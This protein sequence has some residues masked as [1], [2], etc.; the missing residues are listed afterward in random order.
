MPT[1]FSTPPSKPTPPANQR[2][3]FSDDANSPMRELVTTNF[4]TPSKPTLNFSEP[5]FSK[6]SK[7]RS[8]FDDNSQIHY[9]DWFHIL[10]NISTLSLNDTTESKENSESKENLKKKKKALLK[11]AL[12]NFQLQATYLPEDLKRLDR[13]TSPLVLE[14]YARGIKTGLWEIAREIQQ[15]KLQAKLNDNQKKIIKNFNIFLTNRPFDYKASNNTEIIIKPKEFN[16]IDSS[17]NL[18]DSNTES[19]YIKSLGLQLCRASSTENKGKE[20]GSINQLMGA[21]G[22]R[23]SPNGSAEIISSEMIEKKKPSDALKLIINQIKSPNNKPFVNH[24]QQI[25]SKPN[26]KVALQNSSL[27]NGSDFDEMSNTRYKLSDPAT[28][29]PKGYLNELL[30]VHTDFNN[31]LTSNNNLP[32]FI[33]QNIEIL[34]HLIGNPS[35][36]F[37]KTT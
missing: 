37:K 8:F 32:F 15:S 10:D 35:D 16:T 26:N 14:G 29:T 20:A 6:D 3:P 28:R 18:N 5:F 23:T 12:T 33:K 19:F 9:R 25:G 22:L 11:F 21:K 1:N 27:M 4:S 31:Q 2:K 13:Q 30:R 24:M 34:Q 7:E 17:V 36:F